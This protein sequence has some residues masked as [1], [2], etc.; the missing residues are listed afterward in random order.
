MIDPRK[1]TDE[2]RRLRAKLMA[3][4]VRDLLTAEDRRQAHEEADREVAADVARA[5]GEE[6]PPHT[7]EN[8][9]GNGANG[10]QTSTPPPAPTVP[11]EEVERLRQAEE[12][13]RAQAAAAMADTR[14]EIQ[15]TTE[16]H[17][18]NDQA[19]AALAT[20]PIVFQQH[21]VG[22][23]RV[24]RDSGE[25]LERTGRGR[26]KGSPRVGLL[27]RATLRERLS[28]VAAWKK[29]NKSAKTW[30]PAHPPDWTVD[31]LAARGDWPGVRRLDG[32]IEAPAV[33]DDGSVIEA[34]GYDPAT[35]LLYEP[36]GEVLPVPAGETQA[37][38]AAALARLEEV[39]AD[40]PFQAPAHCAAWLASLLTPLAATGRQWPAPLFLFDANTRGSGK[41]L[42]ADLVAI[43]VTT[44]EMPRMTLS[45]DNEE[46]RKTLLALALGGEPLAFFD[47]AHVLRGAALNAALTGRVVKGRILGESRDVTATMRA[48]FYAAGNNVAVK[49]DTAR[50]VI[51]V[52]LESQEEH[53]E[54]R[55]DFRH[56]DVKAW[57]RS[58]RP[59]LLRDALT[60]LSAYRKA[61]SP[62]Q[63][64]PL[65][66][67]EDWSREVRDPLVWAGAADPC[68]TRAELLASDSEE[69]TLRQLLA[70]WSE[71]G[72]AET[73]ITV[74]TAAERLPRSPTLRE[75]LEEL[76]A[77]TGDKVNT[78]ALGRRLAKHQGRWC[79]GRRLV[80]GGEDRNGVALWRVERKAGP[81]G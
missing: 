52:R 81:G 77:M 80:K 51:H 44:R 43:L 56:P 79:G 5:N 70:G 8:A 61:G 38:A 37:L 23:V 14:P 3:G 67:F 50:R 65:G 53:P 28:A 64:T 68:D 39:V 16:E 21:G 63:R 49:G 13:G 36:A 48:T 45:E 27:P 32:V 29:W 74:R 75:A 35:R 66:S 15:I 1:F 26:P 78:G 76:G 12:Q 33:R 6:P 31:A 42:L 11:E 54:Q 10:A 22:L 30:V 71:V 46:A 18:V 69:H 73:A 58:E 59:K 60:I 41:T 40:F 62:R 55:S 17:A 9:Q 4:E 7:D 34:T 24:L 2:D 57:A 47:E 25:E 72:G 19:V 20:D